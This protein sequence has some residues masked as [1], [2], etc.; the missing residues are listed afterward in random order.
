MQHHQIFAHLLVLGNLEDVATRRTACEWTLLC[1]QNN[2]R[3]HR[4]PGRK[5]WPGHQGRHHR[6]G[7]AAHHDIAQHYLRVKLHARCLGRG[8]ILF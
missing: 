6:R 1:R 2:A 8:F 5:H 3:L 7:C 4:Q